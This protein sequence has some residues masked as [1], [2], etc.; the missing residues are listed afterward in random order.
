MSTLSTLDTVPH[1]PI[2]EEVVDTLCT[3]TQNKDPQFFRIITAYFF[4]KMAASMRAKISTPISL[5]DIPV[6]VYSVALATSGF[7]KG[8]SVSI[9][10]N[11][12]LGGFASRFKK[13]TFPLVADTNLWKRAIEAA[14]NNGTE[15]EEERNKLEAQFKRAGHVPFTF[16]SGT[17]AAIKQVRE[18]LLLSEIG[19]INLQI[20]EIG[21]NLIA[22][23]DILNVFLE[24]YD[25]GQLKQKLIKNTAENERAEDLDGK[26]PANALLFGTP[27][28]LMDGAQTQKAFF[29]FLE[30]GYG[31]RCFFGWGEPE[32]SKVRLSAKER[33]SRLTQQAQS[34]A[35]QKLATHFTLLADPAKFGWEMTMPDDVA[36]TWLEYQNQCELLADQMSEHEDIRKAE[37]QHRHSKAVKLAGAFAFVDESVEI[38]MDHLLQ[39]IKLVEESGATFQKLLNPEEPYVKLAKFLAEVDDK[40]TV[41]ELMTLPYYK[42]ATSQM[43]QEMVRHAASWGYKNHVIIRKTFEDGIEFYEGETLK[44]TD[45]NKMILSYSDHE[46]YNYVTEP[47]PFDKLPMLF[48]SQDMHWTNHRFQK[49]HRSDENVIPGFNMVTVDV[50]GGVS[51]DFVHDAFKD[52]MFITH[53]TKRH[54]DEQHR[55]RLVLPLVYQLELSKEDYGEF[56]DN[57]LLWLPFDSDTSTRQRSKK[58]LTVH[59]AVCHV[60][61]EGK[62][63]DPL[64]FIPKTSRNEEYHKGMQ[65]LSSLDNLERWFAQRIS[66][67][68]RNN[69]M[70]K[71][72]LALVDSGMQFAEV[73]QAV[74]SFNNRINNGLSESELRSSILV[75]VA[76]KFAAAA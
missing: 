41:A 11:K 31:R 46:A 58:W 28:K 4:G 20:D 36:L 18:K 12:F 63:L 24:L 64:P 43:R 61:L 75:T 6:N 47:A 55:F 49:G 52:H 27:S 53:T 65:E 25:Q 8:Y 29:D 37:M 9:M 22:S 35:A 13:D 15:E 5:D 40:K 33:F 10:E 34:K 74:M 44:E 16:D 30:T 68:D 23:T 2:M 38:T 50:D 39:A 66:V 51:L 32:R 73:E 3:Q 42:A 14:A 54:T 56:I 17:P 60:N 71:Y 19:A 67:G 48:Q 70:I 62:L 69:Q 59:Q 1:H 21:S 26:T 72:A 57:L 7:G 45:L 76:K